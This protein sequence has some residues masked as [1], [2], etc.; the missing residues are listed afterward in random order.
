MT[1]NR[2]LTYHTYPMTKINLNMSTL[3]KSWTKNWTAK[4]P[5]NAHLTINNKCLIRLSRRTQTILLKG[6]IS[7][8][9]KIRILEAQSSKYHHLKCHR[10]LKRQLYRAAPTRIQTIN[11][12]TRKWMIQV[13]THRI[14]NNMVTKTQLI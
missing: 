8:W 6:P 7:W 1:N 4:W 10:C 12:A 2:E 9:A 5:I 3:S 14:L 11:K 13:R